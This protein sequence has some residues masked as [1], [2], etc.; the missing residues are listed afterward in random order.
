MLLHPEAWAYLEHS[1]SFLEE[2]NPVSQLMP[3]G[4]AAEAESP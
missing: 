2:I 1:N 4:L 3:L